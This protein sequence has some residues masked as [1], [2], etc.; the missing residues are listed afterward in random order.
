MGTISDELK[1]EI[2][3]EM[4][5]LSEDDFLRLPSSIHDGLGEFSHLLAQCRRDKEALISSGFIW[6]NME[7]FDGYLETLLIAH[8][9]RVATIPRSPEERAKYYSLLAEAEDDRMVLRIVAHH[10][11]QETDDPQL[12]RIYRKVQS[13]AGMID[14]MTDNI[15]FGAMISR[16]W[17]LAEQIRPG[18][19]EVNEEYIKEVRI[20]AITLMQMR[21]LVVTNGMPRCES[22]D[23]QNRIIT[24]CVQAMDYIKRFARSAFYNN[25]PYY[26]SN[27]TRPTRSGGSGSG[28]DD[29]IEIQ[30][31]CMAKDTEPDVV[32]AL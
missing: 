5:A 12:A 2:R 20:R 29:P 22:V 27:Y 7:K 25:L 28:N 19:R 11:L 13:G 10:I 31:I 14:T 23:Y 15:S 18:G 32:P 4:E 3:A 1:K 24:L 21:G 9:E 17:D 26:F 30:P 6:D 16:H 8:G